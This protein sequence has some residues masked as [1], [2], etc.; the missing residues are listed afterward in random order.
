M[1]QDSLQKSMA[2]S[3]R[4]MDVRIGELVRMTE[5]RL[6]LMR[7]TMEQRITAMQTDNSQRLEQMRQTVDEKTA[8]NAGRSGSANPSSRSASGLN[9]YIRD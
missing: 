5:Q 7:N 3:L 8:E 9:R 1:R 6:D 4:T 2:E